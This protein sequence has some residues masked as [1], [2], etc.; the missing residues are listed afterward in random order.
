[1]DTVLKGEIFYFFCIHL[2]VHCVTRKMVHVISLA[3]KFFHRKGHF[4]TV[5]L[6]FILSTKHFA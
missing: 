3:H 1:M 2:F 5:C 6:D 4:E